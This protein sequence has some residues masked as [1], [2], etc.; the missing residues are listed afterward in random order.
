[1]AANWRH[2]YSTDDCTRAVIDS[3]RCL[4]VPETIRLLE[5]FL[6]HGHFPD[7]SKFGRPLLFG[8]VAA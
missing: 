4:A 5:F 6:D 7:E 8:Q 2:Y 1:M 3:G